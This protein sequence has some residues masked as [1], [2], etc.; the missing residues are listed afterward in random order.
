MTRSVSFFKTE[1]YCS[2]L[3]TVFEMFIC[4]F[5]CGGLPKVNSFLVLL[6]FISPLTS[7]RGRVQ[8]PVAPGVPNR[9][10][11]ATP[12]D[13]KSKG[14]ETRGGET[15]KEVTSFPLLQP[16][17]WRST[18]ERQPTNISKPA[19][20]VLE[21]LPSSYKENVEQKWGHSSRQAAKV[22]SVIV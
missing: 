6:P 4:C 3:E 11:L 18:P 9:P 12:T 7:A 14:R 10:G 2:N 22:K 19:S 8:K 20:K 5:L 13:K 1:Y 16:S 15:R 21:I 17:C